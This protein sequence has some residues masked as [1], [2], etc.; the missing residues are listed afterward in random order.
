MT[1]IRSLLIGIICL[2]S[3]ATKTKAEGA[4]WRP[5]EVPISILREGCHPF[6]GYQCPPK[7]ECF[8]DLSYPKYGQCLCRPDFYFTRKQPENTGLE[9]APLPHKDDCIIMGPVNVLAFFSLYHP[10]HCLLLH[11]CCWVFNDE[12]YL[13]RWRAQMEQLLCCFGALYLG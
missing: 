5:D 8:I 4:S 12:S 13:Q 10:H 1:L 3:L 7:M 2:G 11:D 6:S 9:L